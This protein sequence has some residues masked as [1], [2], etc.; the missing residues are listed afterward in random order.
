MRSAAAAPPPWPAI[1]LIGPTGSGKT[2]L[3]DE[4]EKR[5]LGG[6]RCVH[7]DFGANLRRAAGSGAAEFDL[8]T[9]ELE[10]IRASLRS[11]AL[12]EA[13]DLPMI[14]KIL[15]RFAARRGLGTG[16]LLVLNGLPRHRDQAEALAPLLAVERVVSLVADAPVILARIRLDTG[17]DRAGRPDDSLESVARRLKIF[18][19]RTAPLIAYYEECRVPVT[20]FR[21]TAEMTAA[22]MYARLDG[23]RRCGGL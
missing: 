3:G 19:E 12:F 11:G 18:E 21:V 1:L 10:T 14:V 4:L 16:D 23:R 5:G 17:G 22:E 20:A 9:P 15:R 8:G 7:F 6:R 2:P 13:G